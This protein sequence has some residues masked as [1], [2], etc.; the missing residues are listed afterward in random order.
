MSK[1]SQKNR[2]PRGATA[3]VPSWCDDPYAKNYDATLGQGLCANG[4]GN[5]LYSYQTQVRDKTVTID[6]VWCFGCYSKIYGLET[7][8]SLN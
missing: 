6:T 7:S 1:V 2:G 8:E 3:L 4:D 5:P